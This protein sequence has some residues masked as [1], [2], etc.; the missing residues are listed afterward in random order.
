MSLALQALVTCATD[1]TREAERHRREGLPRREKV[2]GL[3]NELAFARGADDVVVRDVDRRP[4]KKAL[5]VEGGAG[6]AVGNG[7]GDH[8]VE[9]VG[10]GEHNFAAH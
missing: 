3:Q 2:V 9:E 7:E 10:H 8:L 6:C 5:L 1:K 4:R